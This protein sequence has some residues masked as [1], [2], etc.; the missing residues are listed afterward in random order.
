MLECNSI[1]GGIVAGSSYIERNMEPDRGGILQMQATLHRIGGFQTLWEANW[2]NAASL[3][4][5]EK[6]K[7]HPRLV[8]RDITLTRTRRGTWEAVI[9]DHKVPDNGKWFEHVHGHHI[10][11]IGPCCLAFMDNCCQQLLP[12][13][14]ARSWNIQIYPILQ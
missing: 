1:V 4:A 5:I 12:F 7:T 3:W 10:P 9:F 13:L 11:V 14:L 6:F 8:D 2:E